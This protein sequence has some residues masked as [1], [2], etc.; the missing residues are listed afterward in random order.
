[1]TFRDD[2]R[3]HVPKP[4]G[5][6]VRNTSEPLVTTGVSGISGAIVGFLLAGN[7]YASLGMFVAALAAGWI[8]RWARG[9]S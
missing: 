9:L 4:K 2:S 6:S 8:G 3:S 7:G 1:M 5:R